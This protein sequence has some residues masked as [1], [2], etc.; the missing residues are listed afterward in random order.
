MQ[1]TYWK[2]EHYF[3]TFTALITKII[4]NSITFLIAL[5]VI[6]FWIFNRDF[7]AQNIH[8][9]IGDIILGITFLT[10]FILQ[11]SFNKFTASIHLKINELVATHDTASNLMINVENKSEY[12]LKELS[13]E[14]FELALLANKEEKENIK[15]EN[16]I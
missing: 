1:N 7:Y 15:K 14:F 6:L 3:E 4:G 8:D 12:E 16:E 11:K 2:I 13:K 9:D 10:L 5:V